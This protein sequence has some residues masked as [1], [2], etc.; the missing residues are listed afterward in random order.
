MVDTV[1]VSPMA[2]FT[3]LTVREKAV[4]PSDHSMV[5]GAAAATPGVDA[6]RPA[7]T[8]S[9]VP[10]AAATRPNDLVMSAVSSVSQPNRLPRLPVSRLPFPLFGFVVVGVVVPVGSSVTGGFATVIVGPLSS[11]VPEPRDPP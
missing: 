3:S 8:N 7:T 4:L 2:G 9:P 5:A 10:V 6:I 1:I 11:Y